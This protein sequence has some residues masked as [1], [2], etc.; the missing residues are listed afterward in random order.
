[1]QSVPQE[2]SFQLGTA[3]W[4]QRQV[5][6]ARRDR[7]L[8]LIRA[9][10]NAG[11][12]SSFQWAQLMAAVLEFKPSLV[13]ELGRSFGNSTCAFNEAANVLNSQGHPCRVVS[14]C[15]SDNWEALVEPRV[16]Q[17]VEES[18]FQSLEALRANILTFDYD[19]VIQGAARCLV[20]WD[21]HGFTVAECALGNILPRIADRP[22]L[23]LMHDMLDVRYLPPESRLYE[24]N[25]L[26]KGNNWSGP[27][28]RLGHIESTVEQAVAIV[29]F[30]SRNGIPLESA[31][32]S[33]RTR[34]GD[35]PGKLQE[36]R[37]VL[38]EELFSLCG[39]WFYFSLGDARQSL[40]FPRFAPPAPEQIKAPKSKGNPPAVRP[41][42]WARI[43]HKLR[44]AA[45]AALK[46]C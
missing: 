43:R 19:R 35:D 31:D 20:F 21:A 46:R 40:T 24:Q 1:M 16:R 13:L 38:G 44:Q 15:L 30:A 45:K 26:W 37:Q 5:L 2:P 23:V 14:L 9:V 32:H 39:N 3:Y 18:W 8:A 36:M 11:D 34:I 4:N 17:V 27:R 41:G 22:N 7:V 10:D 6:R 33:I 29:D 12:L 25:V 42:W 28:V